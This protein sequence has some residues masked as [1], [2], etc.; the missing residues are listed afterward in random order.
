MLQTTHFLPCSKL[1]PDPFPPEWFHFALTALIKGE[2][3]V[4]A[5]QGFGLSNCHLEVT[6]NK[7]CRCLWSIP[8][9][10]VCVGG[11]VPLVEDQCKVSWIWYLLLSVGEHSRPRSYCHI[12]SFTHPQVDWSSLWARKP[13]WDG[14]QWDAKTL[15]GRF[16]PMSPGQTDTASSRPL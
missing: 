4:R 9:D 2:G 10:A 11:S 8:K 13:S 3:E 1:N 6:R 15:P 14:E 7:P 5:H 12:P 16:R